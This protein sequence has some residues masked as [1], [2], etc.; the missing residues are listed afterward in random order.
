MLW[1]L[2]NKP[3]CQLIYYQHTL[4]SL[5]IT[6]ISCS[7]I[8]KCV[9]SE[10]TN[11]RN[12]ASY[13]CCRWYINNG[14]GIS[15]AVADWPIISLWLHYLLLIY[16]NLIM[17]VQV[18]KSYKWLTIECIKH[19]L[20]VYLFLIFIHNFYRQSSWF[21]SLLLLEAKLSLVSLRETNA[22]VELI[23]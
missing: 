23:R 1:F 16:L 11:L 4:V 22:N 10:V 18:M 21:V 14:L 8:A 5:M 12:P 9:T 13:G 2:W 20:L 17:K 6:P 19:M 15:D 3:L 7:Q